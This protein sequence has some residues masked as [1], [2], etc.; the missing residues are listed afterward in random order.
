MAQDSLH[1]YTDRHLP[2]SYLVQDELAFLR[3]YTEPGDSCVILSLHQGLYY[4]ETGMKSPLSGPGY[5]EM[6]LQRDVENIFSQFQKTR[7]NCLVVGLDESSLPGLGL[8]KGPDT[9]F[10]DYKTIAVDP[11]RSMLY[12][13][14]K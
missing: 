11:Y 6:I 4:A 3:Q 13:V 7:L 12:L 2:Q 10:P 5:I 9:V 1:R 8:S 14:P